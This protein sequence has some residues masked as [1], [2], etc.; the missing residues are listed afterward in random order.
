VKVLLPFWNT[1]TLRVL[2][3]MHLIS[4]EMK[5]NNLL[6]WPKNWVVL[7]VCMAQ[8]L[9]GRGDFFEC[10]CTKPCM[11]LNWPRQN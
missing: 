2:S 4:S 3:V 1:V 11:N 9:G 6:R 7:K 5:Q 10:M 8:Q